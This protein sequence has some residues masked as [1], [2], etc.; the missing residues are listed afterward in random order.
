MIQARS[1]RV[2][3]SSSNLYD[4]TDSN[5]YHVTSRGKNDSSVKCFDDMTGAGSRWR[6]TPCYH[7]SPVVAKYHVNYKEGWRISRDRSAVTQWHAT[8]TKACQLTHSKEWQVEH[9][10]RWHL[11]SLAGWHTTHMPG[12]YFSHQTGW[13]VMHMSRWSLKRT[14]RVDQGGSGCVVRASRHDPGG[15]SRRKRP[16]I[17]EGKKRERLTGSQR[18][19]DLMNTSANNQAASH[20]RTSIRSSHKLRPSQSHVCLIDPPNQPQLLYRSPPKYQDVATETNNSS[21]KTF[22]SSDLNLSS[23]PA[24]TKLPSPPRDRYRFSSSEFSGKPFSS[25]HYNSNTWRDAVSQAYRSGLSRS[26]GDS[27]ISSSWLDRVN[28]SWQ[29]RTSCSY[30][31]DVSL[32][33]CAV[34]TQGADVVPEKLRMKLR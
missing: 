2:C 8:N 29:S 27:A 28:H 9:M 4:T 19:R 21:I 18:R 10:S 11:T 15:R 14:T 23:S 22:E 33:Y 17:Q 3:V 6:R 26:W 1:T 25:S 20:Y 34:F 24:E 30:R 7:V 16:T 13:P 32:A 12:C 31:E 5:G